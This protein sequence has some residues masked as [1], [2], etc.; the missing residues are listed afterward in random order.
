MPSGIVSIV[1]LMFNTWVVITGVERWLA[2]AIASIV[3]LIG[4]FL[5]SFSPRSN[6]VALLTGTYLVNT[7]RRRFGG[8]FR[9]TNRYCKENRSSC[10]L[11]WQL[12]REFAY[13]VVVI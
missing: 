9:P 8:L 4:A 11:Y 6:H 13:I 10:I 3:T 1:A 5:M 7:V 2:I 12:K